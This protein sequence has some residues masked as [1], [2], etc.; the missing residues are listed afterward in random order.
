MQLH[1][2]TTNYSANTPSLQNTHQPGVM[3]PRSVGPFLDTFHRFIVGPSCIMEHK[4]LP[5]AVCGKNGKVS[6][7]LMQFC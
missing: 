4:T 3:G 1:Q 7:I 6:P 5:F 2:C